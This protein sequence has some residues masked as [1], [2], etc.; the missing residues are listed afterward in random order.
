MEM[1]KETINLLYGEID[2]IV[3]HCGLSETQFDELFGFMRLLNKLYSGE[4]LEITLAD[5]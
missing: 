1:S 4:P 2:E 3:C 5:E